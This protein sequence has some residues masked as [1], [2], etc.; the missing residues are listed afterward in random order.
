MM[1]IYS[2]SN[3]ANGSEKLMVEMFSWLACVVA[4]IVDKFVLM[5][6]S[7]QIDQQAEMFKKIGANDGSGYV[8]DDEWPR[9]F[10]S[11]TKINFDRLDAER[12]DTCAVRCVQMDHVSIVS[13]VEFSF[14]SCGRKYRN[15]CAGIDEVMF[16]VV[17]VFDEQTA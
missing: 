2:W 6:I 14:V 16:F 12:C 13:C 3:S 7:P 4:A 1:S 5:S 15:V 10:S 8:C 9:E 17:G 11:E